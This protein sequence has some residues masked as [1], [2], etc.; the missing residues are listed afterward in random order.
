MMVDILRKE[1]SFQRCA[2]LLFT[3]LDFA[4][5]R[6]AL[7]GFKTAKFTSLD[8]PAAFVG[9]PIFRWL[10]IGYLWFHHLSLL[11]LPYPL[12]FDYSMGCIQLINSYS[13]PRLGLL[14]LLPVVIIVGYYAVRNLS[15]SDQRSILFGIIF[16]AFA[17]FP[18][19]N[20]AFTVGFTVA[21]R[22]LY[23][24]SIGYCLLLAIA[25]K[26]LSK[27]YKS[28]EIIS[29]VIMAMAVSHCFAR[30][31][32]WT[33]EL[34][35]YS[36][37]LEVCPNNAKIHYNL[38]KVLN[39]LGNEA[40][41]ERNYW[42]AIHLHPT[43][44]QALN[45]LG[46][47]LERNGRRDQAEQLLK[48][49]LQAK[50]HFAGAWMNL[51]ISQMNSGK[52]NEA[53]ASFDRSLRLR[54]NSADCHFNLGNLYQR[55]NRLHKAMNAWRNAT[56]IDPTHTKS[57]INLLVVLDELDDCQS[58][59]SL[60][61]SVLTHF[62]HEPTILF[63]LGSC[64]GQLGHYEMA[65]QLLQEAISI[66][67]ENS[68]YHTNLGVLYERWHRYSDAEVSYRRAALLESSDQ[69]T[70]STA[71]ENLQALTQKRDFRKNSTRHH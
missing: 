53:E 7:N 3:A 20:I 11:I 70:I 40:E 27:I 6:L 65:E 61:D 22:V 49:A 55:T 48:R 19:S 47:L 14:L 4:L 63:Q 13:D 69:K 24:P 23:L 29:L 68:L 60:S 37:G 54:P 67:P 28:L 64:F 46:N 58:A 42:N 5:I 21:E 56:R 25:Y 8:N 44:D 41:A 51:G 59:I 10:N 2:V 50:P 62:P 66:S 18:A 35:L 52:F 1:F 33:N 26:Y 71:T 43:Y 57:W 9:D 17:M 38:G 36:S 39:D 16:G 34:S 15:D 12:C 30:S 32:E 31:K 45:N